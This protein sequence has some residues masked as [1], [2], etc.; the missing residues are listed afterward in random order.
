M[1]AI[2]APGNLI[3]RIAGGKVD[4]FKEFYFDYTSPNFSEKVSKNLVKLGK[5][6]SSRTEMKVIFQQNL[7]TEFEIEQL[8]INYSKGLF[9]KSGKN[10]STSLSVDSITL[11]EL[12]KISLKDSSFVNFV[13]SKLGLN[14][15]IMAIQKKCIQLLGNEKVKELQAKLVVDREIEFRRLLKEGGYDEKYYTIIAPK[16]TIQEQLAPTFTYEVKADDSDDSVT[17]N[18]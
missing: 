5:V 8:A 2:A 12:E 3:A 6:L 7:N 15:T 16:L 18:K 13:D 4:D 14:G 11:T 1:K 10:D 9:I 17:K